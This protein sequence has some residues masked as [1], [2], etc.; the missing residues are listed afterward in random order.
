MYDSLLTKVIECSFRISLLVFG[1]IEKIELYKV[2]RADNKIHFNPKKRIE[3]PIQNTS[4]VSILKKYHPLFQQNIEFASFKNKTS[5]Q[6]RCFK[7]FHTGSFINLNCGR[8]L[9]ITFVTKTPQDLDSLFIYNYHN[10]VSGIE[11]VSHV[12][13]PNL[14]I[15]PND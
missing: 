5:L 8:R 4:I 12:V 11:T 15:E 3:I 10:R 6:P 1:D 13:S 2:F 9:L 7:Q 14:I